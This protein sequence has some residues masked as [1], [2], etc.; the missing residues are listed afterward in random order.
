MR[1]SLLLVFGLAL[2]PAAAVRAACEEPAGARIWW[3]PE[4]PVAGEPLRVMAV[5]E[6][7]GSASLV[8]VA[9][10]QVEPL[11]VVERGGPPAS[12]AAEIAKPAAGSLR[13]ELRRG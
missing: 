4:A 9:G 7:E 13:V 5:V 12:F 10:K 3:S 2:L 11:T 8:R 1:L 6:K